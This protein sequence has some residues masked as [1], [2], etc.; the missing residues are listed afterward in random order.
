MKKKTMEMAAGVGLV[1]ALAL[2]GAATAQDQSRD[3]QT[4]KAAPAA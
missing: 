2:T 3:D 1:V 4:R